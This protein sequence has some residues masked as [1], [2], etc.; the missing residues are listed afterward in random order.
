MIFDEFRKIQVLNPF[1]STNIRENSCRTEILVILFL[2]R[3]LS[4][5]GTLSCHLIALQVLVVGGDLIDHSAVR[6]QLDDTVGGSLYNLVV[7]GGEQQHARE[8]DE[9]EAFRDLG[10][11]I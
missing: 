10:W 1:I 9:S 7:T 6:Q 5:D 4:I 11:R 8:L 3:A 2:V